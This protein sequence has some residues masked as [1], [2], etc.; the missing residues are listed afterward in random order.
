[1]DG[2]D[3]VCPLDIVLNLIDELDWQIDIRVP[4]HLIVKTLILLFFQLD[5]VGVRG[6]LL[7]VSP[8]VNL[9]LGLSRD[10]QPTQHPAG[11]DYYIALTGRVDGILL[12]E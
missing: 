2:V 11:H 7:Q 9:A 8:F 12:S 6:V 4:A 5:V 3:E 10:Q 1:M